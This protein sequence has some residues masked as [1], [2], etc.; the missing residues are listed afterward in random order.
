MVITICMVAALITFAFQTTLT[1]A[2]TTAAGRALQYTVPSTNQGTSW[3]LSK[4]LQTTMLLAL[5][6]TS[7][8][9]VRN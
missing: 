8:H 2:R 7:P 5:F 3:D 1:T 4:A 9:V 6:V